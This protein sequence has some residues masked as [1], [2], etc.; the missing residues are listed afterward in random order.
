MKIVVDTEVCRGHA[1]CIAY[2]PD[3]FVM[4][5]D[6]Y[7][8]TKPTLVPEGEEVK[9]KRAALSCPERAI[10]IVDAEGAI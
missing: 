3:M 5:E 7:N 9:A 6:G 10:T 4:N 2:A 8:V 1:R